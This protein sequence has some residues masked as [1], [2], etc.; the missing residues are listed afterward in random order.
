MTEKAQIDEAYHK[1]EQLK[2][3][4]F[5]TILK[6]VGNGVAFGFTLIAGVWVYTSSMKYE[7]E[8]VIPTT[9][10]GRSSIRQFMKFVKF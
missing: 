7:K 1:D 9:E 2:V 6:H 8:G 10:G 5:D 4:K 3:S